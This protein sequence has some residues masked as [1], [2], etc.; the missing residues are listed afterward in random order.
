MNAKE[1]RIGNYV[2]SEQANEYY[3]ILTI[4]EL[5][6]ELIIAEDEGGICFRNKDIK[7]IIITDK[8]LFKLGFNKINHIHGYDFFTL[9][10]SKIN[11][12][13]IDIYDKNT[14]YMGYSVLHC[15]YVHQLQNLY[16]ALTG[17]EL[18]IKK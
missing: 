13:N 10:N 9:H 16:F 8:W 17:K 3:E 6:C 2:T 15:E 5:D 18:E 12:C 1:L 7:P 14:K 11:K 4:V